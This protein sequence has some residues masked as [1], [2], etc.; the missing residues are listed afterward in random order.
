MNI[1][2]NLKMALENIAA[3]KM[4]S[5]LTMLGIIIGIGSVIMIIAA[6]NGGKQEI[7][8][9]V[10]Q[11]GA[12]TVQIS[13]D[14]QK[15]TESDYFTF[16]DIEALK[17]KVPELQYVSPVEQVLG[18]V[19]YG[20][21][22]MTGIF[23][24]GTPDV[25]RMS[26]VE[27]LTG[28]FYTQ[29]DFNAARNVIVLDDRAAREFFGDIDVVGLTVDVTLGRKTVK[30]KIIGVYKSQM[31][32]FMYEGMPVIPYIPLSTYLNVS[33]LSDSF[34]SLT[35]MADSKDHTEAMG[36]TAQNVLESRHGNRGREV[37]QLQNMAQAMDAINSVI[38]LF[39]TFIAAVAAIS[40][41]VGGIG[42]MNIML[43]SVTERTREIG[44]RKSLGA[45]THNILAQFLTESAILTL[46]GGAIGILFGVVGAYAICALL[47]T[48]PV[49]DAVTILFTL[50]F[51]CSVGI[52]F[53]IYPARKAARLNP[54][55]ALRHQ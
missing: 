16:E 28:R 4:R 37:Y 40:L 25:E 30:L 3:N 49:I 19:A 20:N 11:M 21:H 24:A 5:F 12:A 50:A 46:I 34:S 47:G 48:A 7:M 26:S 41:V 1:L 33:G 35:M 23:A 10:E 6:G 14:N 52:F 53:G 45:K 13:V 29:E 44:I 32:E 36:T 8:S 18:T 55:D 27:M 22:S 31:G 2:E 54:I 51:S 17:A 38:S 39:Q 9:Q 42:V 15:A 43:V